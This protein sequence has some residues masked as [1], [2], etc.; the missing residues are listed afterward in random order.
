MKYIVFENKMENITTYFALTEEQ[1]KDERS[2]VL[3]DS[4]VK[5]FARV[6]TVEEMKRLNVERGISY[7]RNG[8][9]RIA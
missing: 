2:K 4:D 1:I 3:F 8:K 7:M 5:E 6:N 9:L